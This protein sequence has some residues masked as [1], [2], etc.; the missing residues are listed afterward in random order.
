MLKNYGYSRKGVENASVE[1]DRKTLSPTY[2][3]IMGL[4]GESRAVDIASRNGFPPAL[5][6]KARGY[7]DEERSDVSALIT[8]LKEKHRELDNAS[9]S[10]KKEQERLREDRRKADLKALALRQKEHFLKQEGAAEFRRFL[11]ESRK[12]LEN[13]VREIRE[14]ELS[15]EKTLKVKDFIRELEAR[16]AAFS[17]ALEEEEAE[18][19]KIAAEIDAE[20]NANAD[21]KCDQFNRAGADHPGTDLK[22]DHLNRAADRTGVDLK[23]DQLKVEPGAEV[24]AGASR[25]RGTVIRRDNKQNWVVEIGSVRMS[26]PERELVPVKNPADGSKPGAVKVGWDAELAAAAPKLE[27]NFLGMKLDEALDALRRQIDAAVLAGL[28]EFSV[29]HGKGDGILQKGVHD[30]LSGDPAVAE[31]Y[32]SRPELGGFGRTEVVLK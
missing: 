4:P 2:R 24:L 10:A 12:S 1:F 7:L 6:E 8:G 22:R 13:L 20:A 3:I 30:Y 31:F 9:R 18:L 26:F 25:Q 17:S 11:S 5:V 32:F 14:G 29:V 21:L 28:R 15:R 23:R 16:S 27:I 19:V